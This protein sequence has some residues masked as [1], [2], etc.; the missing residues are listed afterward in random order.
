MSKK[1]VIFIGPPGSGKGTIAVLLEK[2]FGFEHIESSKL[3]ENK[4]KNM[5]PGDSDWDEIEKEKKRFNTGML[6][7]PPFIF[8]LMREKIKEMSAIEKNIVLSG[9]PRT[10][11][12]A[13][14]EIPILIEEYGRENIYIINMIVSSEVSI[15]RNSKRRICEKYRHP[16][17][18]TPGTENL[19][20]CPEDGSPLIKRG[21][22]DD[23]ETIKIRI[24]EY[25]ERTE[26]ILEYIEKEFGINPVVIDGENPVDVRFKETKKAV[27]L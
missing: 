14:D 4:F 6:T 11:D 18:W 20:T 3:I 19:T 10:L 2:N 21:I 24:R 7:S 17:K 22:L 16:I 9:A 23:P 15:A 13:K 12:E 5:K 25:T 8:K 1:A 26:P 27:G